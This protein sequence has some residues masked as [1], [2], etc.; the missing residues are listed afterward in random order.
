[1]NEPLWT[2]KRIHEAVELYY[3]SVV[4]QVI[5]EH[6]MGKM[7]DEHEERIAELEC[8]LAEYEGEL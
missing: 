6:L 3:E 8:R 5:P 1:V 7:R 4:D 2:D